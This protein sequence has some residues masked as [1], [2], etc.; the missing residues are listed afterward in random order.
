MDLSGHSQGFDA[1]GQG[2]DSHAGEIRA[3]ARPGIGEEVCRG[4]GEE[5]WVSEGEIDRW[6]NWRMGEARTALTSWDTSKM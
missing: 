5:G 3:G 1:K 2:G 6:S 4:L